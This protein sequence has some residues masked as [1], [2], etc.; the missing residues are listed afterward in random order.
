MVYYF[1]SEHDGKQFTLYMG[2]DKLENEDLI[3]FGWPMDVWFHVND[4]SS[5]HVYLRMEEGMT[6]KQIPAAV[7][8]D[9]AQ[10]V[11]ANSIE[12]NKKTTGKVRIVYTAWSNLYKTKG[13]ADGQ[14]GFSDAK[15][16]LYTEV[17]ARE[18]AVINRLEKTRV[19]KATAFIRES[20]EAYDAGVRA[21][22]KAAKRAYAAQVQADKERFAEEKEARS[23]DSLF[24]PE[25]MVSNAELAAAASS[26]GGQ[27]NAEDD[28]M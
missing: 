12:G 26:S 7:L 18:N 24:K 8:A 4:L 22:E 19:E 6:L 5:A 11:K 16:C 15:Q 9:C 23:Y 3:R 21:K 13:M 2:R 27:M 1:T 28:F 10:L 25:L 17:I 20:K 14:V